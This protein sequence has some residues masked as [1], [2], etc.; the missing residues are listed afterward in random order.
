MAI[1]GFNFIKLNAERKSPPKGKININN[2]VSIKDV[3]SYDMFLGKNKQAG[4]KFEFEF[5]SVYSP[6]VASILIT[7]EVLYLGTADEN[8]EL[9]KAWK[10]DKKIKKEILAEILNTALARASLEALMISREFNLPPPIPLP[11]V[12]STELDKDYIG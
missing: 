3:A 2:N 1:V 11:K 6:E 8:E 12:E 10:K 7:G 5:T 9:L 4:L